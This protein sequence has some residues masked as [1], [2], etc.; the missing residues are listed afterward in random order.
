MISQQMYRERQKP[1][2]KES[3]SPCGTRATYVGNRLTPGCRCDLC[4]RAN[5]QYMAEYRAKRDGYL[6][7]YLQN[8]QRLSDARM[9]ELEEYDDTYGGL[10]P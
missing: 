10:L 1:G 3:L 7:E 2:P 9:E 5:R 8:L 6:D 4:K